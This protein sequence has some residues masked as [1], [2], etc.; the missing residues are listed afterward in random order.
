MFFHLWN[1]GT[2]SSPF[3]R[4][5]IF[6]PKPHWQ[7]K[8]YN[9]SSAE[10]STYRGTQHWWIIKL[11]KNCRMYKGRGGGGVRDRCIKHIIKEMLMAYIFICE[12][13][14]QNNQQQLRHNFSAIKWTCWACCV[15]FVVPVM[16]I[17]QNTGTRRGGSLSYTSATN[18]CPSTSE[19]D[20]NGV[21]HL[22][23]NEPNETCEPEKI[24]F[25]FFL[26]CDQCLKNAPF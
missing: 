13:M 4:L 1:V 25:F 14:P 7:A 20:P 21:L 9:S 15:G 11:G 16:L 10:V 8:T 5:Q 2:P 3:Q 19:M 26:L 23:W 6:W 24:P 12:W 22:F 17:C 18:P